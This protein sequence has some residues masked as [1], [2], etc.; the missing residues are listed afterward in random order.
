MKL[1]PET[2]HAISDL[3]SVASLPL[4]HVIVGISRIE[5]LATDGPDPSPPK[6]IILVPLYA[7]LNG[8]KNKKISKSNE[9]VEWRKSQDIIRIVLV[10]TRY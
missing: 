2:E 9:R 5:M 10:F 6:R 4:V 3:A 7:T 1:S 8:S